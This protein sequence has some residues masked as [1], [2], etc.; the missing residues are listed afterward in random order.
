MQEASIELAAVRQR[1]QDSTELLQARGE[2]LA[3]CQQDLVQA[4]Q[5]RSARQWLPHA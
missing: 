4:R 1:E 2:A 5:V 3:D